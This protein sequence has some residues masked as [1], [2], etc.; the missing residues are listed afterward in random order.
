M[1]FRYTIKVFLGAQNKDNLKFRDTIKVFL[2]AQNKD[3]LSFRD[4]KFDLEHKIKTL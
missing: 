1:R 3:Y 2:G 4:I